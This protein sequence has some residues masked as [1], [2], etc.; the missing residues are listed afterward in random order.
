MNRREFLKG[1]ALAGVAAVAKGAVGA[2]GLEVAKGF[3]L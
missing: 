3:V 2:V 1:G